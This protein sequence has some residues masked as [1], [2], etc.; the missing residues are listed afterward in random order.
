MV[1]TPQYYSNAMNFISTG[2]GYMQHVFYSMLMQAKTDLT[3][4]FVWERV[5][6]FRREAIDSIGGIYDKSKSE[7]I[8]TVMR[9]HE[10]GWRTVYINTGAMEGKTPETMKKAYSKQQLRW[11]AG[12]LK[13]SHNR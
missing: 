11:A 10:G 1:Q 3:P 2:A 12:V 4:R 7:D 13:Y 8:W 5:A 6:L 9:L